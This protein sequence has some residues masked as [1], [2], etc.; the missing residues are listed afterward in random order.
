MM[1]EETCCQTLGLNRSTTSPFDQEVVFG[2]YDGP[3]NGIVRCGHCGR[4]FRYDLLDL[5]LPSEEG[6][7]RIFE[8][9]PIAE[10]SL[11]RFIAEMSAYQ[12]PKRPVWVPLWSF[13]SDPDREK[14]NAL[15]DELLAGKS[16]PE[17]VVATSTW[18]TDRILVARSI[19]DFNSSDSEDGF[20]SLGLV[21]I[22]ADD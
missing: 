21:R 16:S 17:W 13:P 11:E 15:V 14:M 3:T 2:Y 22:P 12:E 6:D 4:T 20:A 7:T 8:V 18:L 9:S 10:G 19:S 1:E 5:H